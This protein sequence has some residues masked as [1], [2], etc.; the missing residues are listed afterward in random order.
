MAGKVDQEIF[1]K[2]FGVNGDG[3]IGEKAIET[4]RVRRG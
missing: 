4:A 1:G 2:K 3:L